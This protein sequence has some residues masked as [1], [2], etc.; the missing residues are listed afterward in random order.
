MSLQFVLAF[1]LVQFRGDSS[2]PQDTTNGDTGDEHNDYLA[3]LNSY[4]YLLQEKLNIKHDLYKLDSILEDYFHLTKKYL[5]LIE[6]D[7]WSSANLSTAFTWLSD[8]FLRKLMQIC[9]Q[10]DARDSLC[11]CFVQLFSNFVLIF[12]IDYELI[13]SKIVPIFEKLLNINSADSDTSQQSAIEQI[14]NNKGC[15][16]YK[17]ILPVYFVGILST[18]V[19]VETYGWLNMDLENLSDQSMH[20]TSSYSLKS[21]TS[22]SLFSNEKVINSS[23]SKTAPQKSSSSAKTESKSLAQRIEHM[24]TYLKNVFFTLSLNQTNLD[25]LVSIYELMK[26]KS[27]SS[28]YVTQMLLSTL[29][30]GIVHVSLYVRCNTA[31]LFEILVQNCD[32]YLLSTRILPAL[33]TLANDLDKMVRCSS[34]SPLTSIIE[35]CSN[36]EILERVYTQLQAFLSDPILKDEYLLQIELL[37]TFRRISTK[38]N[39]KFREECKKMLVSIIFII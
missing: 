5:N 10:V 20:S 2:P 3:K 6:T 31:K 26:N 25:G 7:S 32:E 37:K 19:D 27:K 8:R 13:R 28:E 23:F 22:P 34:I 14:L 29:W 36:K 24:N 21:E 4:F 9:A 1:I 15:P 17:A 11:A 38:V 30:D 18:L 12:A 33:I 35:N 16:L 39:S